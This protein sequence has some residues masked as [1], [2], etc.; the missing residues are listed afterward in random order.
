MTTH[1][2]CCKIKLM[3]TYKLSKQKNIRD[4]GGL[5]GYQGK[6]VKSNKIFRGGFIPFLTNEDKA[7]IDSF[8]LTDVVDFRGSYEFKYKPEVKLDNVR[9]HNF[10]PL[11]ENVA[12]EHKH[13]DDGNLLW[14]VGKDKTGYQH[15]FET[16]G[17]MIKS[18]EAKQAY[19]NFFRL[20]QSSDDLV[21]YFHCSQGKDRAGMAAYFLE[22]ALGV[23][24]EDKIA[25]YLLSNEAMKERARSAAN[26][27]KDKPF[28]NEEYEQSLY[29]VFSA[30]IE[31]LENAK[32]SMIEVSGSVVEY[33]KKELGA[34]IDKLRKIYLE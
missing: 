12:E 25:D 10:P 6:K 18:E 26:A 13:N 24:E 34:D 9:Y 21:V 14:F 17:E 27:V 32:R 7:I 8:H 4:L 16:Y 20:L 33:I 3:K 28:Y 19:R 5:V 11:I 1:K 23:S 2:K 22:T 29:D 30:K 31:F 15:M